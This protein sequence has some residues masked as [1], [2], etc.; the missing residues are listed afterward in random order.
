[1]KGR[2]YT[3]VKCSLIDERVVKD[4]LNIE[5]V[6]KSKRQVFKFPNGNEVQTLG[7]LKLWVRLRS[8]S[9]AEAVIFEV[10]PDSYVRNRY[11]ALLSDDLI[12]IFP[13]D[14]LPAALEDSE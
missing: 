13:T 3:G 1:M 7:Q 5:Q 11:D 4:R 6:D 8:V 14:C 10:I 12:S 2:L 9:T